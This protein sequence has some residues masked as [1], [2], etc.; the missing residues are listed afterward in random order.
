M[1]SLASLVLVVA[2]A[3]SAAPA[4]N[5]AF[6]GIRMGDVGV[7][8]QVSDTVAGGP[9][10]EAGV[11]PLDLIIAVDGVPLTGPPTTVNTGACNALIA[12]VVAH[13]PGD[14]IK[15]DIRRG[16]DPITIQ[17]ALSTRA[18]VLHRRLVGHPLGA[19]E[20]VDAE[21]PRR[22][23]DL[24][25]AN[26]R[27]TVL[28][29]VSDDACTGCTLVFDKLRDQLRERMRGAA[30][31]DVLAVMHAPKA[32]P[33]TAPVKRTFT[34]SVP[35]ALASSEMVLDGELLEADRV[36]FVIVDGRGIVRFVAPIAPQAE[37][38]DA[39]LDEVLAAAEQLARPLRR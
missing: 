7:G 33:G 3:A 24:G 32:Q 14:T 22:S 9:A 39:A 37:D 4:S 17:V 6:I 26:G 18:E 29:W 16:F 38:V 13:G 28:G 12:Q 15:L 20:L 34:S 8:C 19:V 25:E 10:R 30:C 36:L 5:P 11:R 27:V 21:D 31:P 1:R 23:Y 35:L 2:S